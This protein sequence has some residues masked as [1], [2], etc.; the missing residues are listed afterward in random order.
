MYKIRTKKV[1][2]ITILDIKVLVAHF[3]LTAKRS[4]ST[5]LNSICRMADIFACWFSSSREEKGKPANKT[6]HWYKSFSIPYLG[7]CQ[8]SSQ[9]FCSFSNTNHCKDRRRNATSKQPGRSLFQH[10]STL[11]IMLVRN[12]TFHALLAYE[13]SQHFWEKHLWCSNNMG[14]VKGKKV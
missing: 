13:E 14:P 4:W 1:F 2:E 9:H 3:W 5:H 8:H 10:H 12:S 6:P 7:T 11:N